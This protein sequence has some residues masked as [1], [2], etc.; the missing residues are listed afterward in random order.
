M[1]PV[2]TKRQG[3]NIL[4]LGAGAIGG[5]FGARLIEAGQ[6]VSFLVRQPRKELLDTNGLQI[7]SQCGDFASPVRAMT[8]VASDDRYDVVILSCKAYDLDSAIAAVRPAVGAQTA[9]L[10]LLNG[11]AHM[12]RLNLA[13]GAQRVLGGLAKIVIAQS[14]DGTIQ[15]LND[16]RTVIFGEQSGGLTARVQ[17]LQE[18][19]PQGSV[20]AKGVPD[21]QQQMWEKLVHLSTVA[22][23]TCLMRA[24]VGEIARVPGGT[25]IFLRVLDIHAEIASREGHPPPETFLADYRRLFADKTAPYVP[26]ILRDIERQKPIEG[27]HIVGFMLDKARKHGLDASL[28]EIAYLHLRAYEERR[29]AG[30]L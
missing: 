25:E 6:D 11:L 27:D 3:M 21:I 8:S 26:S 4:V 12:E 30:R 9:V 14:S 22:T 29:R 1:M 23:V 28:H 10:P 24:S 18:A 16:W 20:L 17:A 7:T 5:Y 15:H 2:F 13:F 19:F